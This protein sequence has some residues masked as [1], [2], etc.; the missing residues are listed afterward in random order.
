MYYPSFLFI[1]I[2]KMLHTFT[3]CCRSDSRN[4]SSEIPNLNPQEKE[5]DNNR[6]VILLSLISI[7]LFYLYKQSYIWIK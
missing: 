4:D 2:G 7:K 5:F 3:C 1:G 6:Q